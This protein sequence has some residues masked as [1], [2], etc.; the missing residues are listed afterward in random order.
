MSARKHSGQ[1]MD[2]RDIIKKIRVSKGA[3]QF[4]SQKIENHL[5]PPPNL[6]NYQQVPSVTQKIV[7]RRHFVL[8]SE[9]E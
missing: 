5:L 4:D 7:Y 8:Y 6:K 3:S 2:I 1:S 9:Y